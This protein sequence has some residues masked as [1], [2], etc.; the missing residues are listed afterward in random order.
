MLRGIKY[1]S[2]FGIVEEGLDDV[3]AT[4]SVP[5]LTVSEKLRVAL[6]RGSWETT[7]LRNRESIAP[8]R[9]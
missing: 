2:A 9:L 3:E 4:G 5:T 7:L 6:D 8:M 1:G